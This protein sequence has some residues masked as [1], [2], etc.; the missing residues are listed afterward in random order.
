MGR[1]E[2][3]ISR[4]I[5][6]RERTR[7]REREREKRRKRRRKRRRRRRKEEGRRRNTYTHSEIGRTSCGRDHP[8]PC[9]FLFPPSQRPFSSRP[10]K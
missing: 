2:N 6:E 4:R 7:E 9:N 3:G 8:A 1:T 5:R 10:H